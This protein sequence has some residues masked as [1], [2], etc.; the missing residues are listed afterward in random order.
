MNIDEVL[1]CVL[2]LENLAVFIKDICERGGEGLTNA[3]YVLI[4][5]QFCGQSMR[6]IETSKVWRSSYIGYLAPPY[7]DVP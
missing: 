5:A 7:I 2:E 3:K 1:K 4:F 6:G